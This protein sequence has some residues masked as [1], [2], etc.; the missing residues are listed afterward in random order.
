MTCGRFA[1]AVDCPLGAAQQAAEN[2]RLHGEDTVANH[3]T[4]YLDMLNAKEEGLSQEIVAESVAVKGTFENI[5]SVANGLLPEK[6]TELMDGLDDQLNA[7]RLTVDQMD[8]LVD[9]QITENVIADF[10]QRVETVYE[11]NCE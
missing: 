6:V 9:P 7:I 1:I 2:A 11:G 8:P 4:A 5:A 10:N 3:K